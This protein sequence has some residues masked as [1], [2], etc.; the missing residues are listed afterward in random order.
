MM[1]SGKDYIAKDEP[2]NEDRNSRHLRELLE[3]IKAQPVP[4]DTDA[5]APEDPPATLVNQAKPILKLK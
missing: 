5:A 2:E 1:R 4:A 3:T